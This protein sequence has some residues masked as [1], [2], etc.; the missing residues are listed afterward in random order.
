MSRPDTM[1][2][3]LSHRADPLALP[4][5]NAHYP[6]QTHASPQFV[7]PGSCLVLRTEDR[8]ALW[9]TLWQRP[10]YTDHAWPGAWVCSLFRNEGAGLSSELIRE[11][12]AATRWRYGTPP[13]AG[14]VTFVDASQVRSP[15]PGYCFRCAGFVRVGE[16]ASGKLAFRLAPDAMP[17]PAAPVGGQYSILRGAA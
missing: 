17:E 1:R 6:R 5:A 14:M 7:A 13:A 3:V 12:V 4:L 11:A 10:E 2:W 8:R 9:V 16:T 15:N